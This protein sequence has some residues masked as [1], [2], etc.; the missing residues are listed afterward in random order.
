[1]YSSAQ[2]VVSTQ[3]DSYS[4]G[5]ASV[6]FTIGEVIIDTG[7]DGSNDVTQGFH[8]TNWKFNGLDDFAP[9][10]SI[11]VYPNPVQSDLNVKTESVSDIFFTLYDVEG[12]KV[13]SDKLDGQLTSIRVQ[14]LPAGSYTL[15]FKDENRKLKSYKLIK[16]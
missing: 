4:N 1:M 3:G 5:S 15:N 7:S 12:R 9:E 13:L 11:E 6:D 14:D 2:E 8:Q 16:Q 10:I